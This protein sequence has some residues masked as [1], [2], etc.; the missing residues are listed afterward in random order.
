MK[1]LIVLILV[2]LTVPAFA[3]NNQVTKGNFVV[4][5]PLFSYWTGMGD[6]DE[7]SEF[8][9]LAV[10]YESAVQYFFMDNLAIGGTAGYKSEE[11]AGVKTKTTTFGPVANYYLTMITAPVLPYAGAAILYEQEKIGSEK[12]T[13]T[14]L[15]FQG[16][17]VYMLGKYLAAYGEGFIS[18][19]AKTKVNGG[20][21]FSGQ[22]VGIA[23]G[24]K[25]FF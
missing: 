25:A 19:Y 9:F 15:R 16:G 20:G 6:I 5:L 12:T 4:T 21:S 24:V 14:E 7:S 22:K 18:P 3:A 10:G 1:K 8:T 23:A 11:S 17:A 2:F 13:S